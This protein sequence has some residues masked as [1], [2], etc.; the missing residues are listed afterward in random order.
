MRDEYCNET[1]S[2]ESKYSGN[3]R[4]PNDILLV[5]RFKARHNED[6]LPSMRLIGARE[7]FSR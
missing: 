5:T 6:I 2:E 4:I 3:G 7:N 1:L